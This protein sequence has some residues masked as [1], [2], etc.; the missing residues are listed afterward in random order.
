[1][2]G[3]PDL[4]LRGTEHIRVS[5]LSSF[6][7]LRSHKISSKNCFKNSPYTKG[8]AQT[9]FALIIGVLSQLVR[10]TVQLLKADS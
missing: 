9:E 2:R 7:L 8:V 4:A 10:N 6:K 3:D 1:M 5:A